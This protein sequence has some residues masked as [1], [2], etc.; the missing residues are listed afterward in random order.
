MRQ[1][2]PVREPVKARL[3]EAGSDSDR[4]W[5]A[6]HVG[7][8]YRIRPE[9]AGER[10]VSPP[11]AAGCQ[12]LIVVRQIKVGVRLK[13]SVDLPGIISPPLNSESRAG[14]LYREVLARTPKLQAIEAVLEEVG[15]T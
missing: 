4:D 11:P 13:G 14:A 7:R 5:F 8:N 10:F 6:S 9:I 2:R 15:Q 12:R 1:G 3:M